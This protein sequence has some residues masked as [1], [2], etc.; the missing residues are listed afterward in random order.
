MSTQKDNIDKKTAQHKSQDEPE[1][2]DN[3]E[4]QDLSQNVISGNIGIQPDNATSSAPNLEPSNTAFD[5]A[6]KGDAFTHP[7]L[8]ESLLKTYVKKILKN[9]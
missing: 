8:S 6:R 2:D 4:D 9:R 3:L 5:M 7:S 1:I